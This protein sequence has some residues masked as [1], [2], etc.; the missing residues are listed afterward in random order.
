MFDSIT[1]T[2]AL[3]EHLKRTF[4]KIEYFLP[5][6]TRAGYKK[7]LDFIAATKHYREVCFMA[8]NRVGKSEAVAYC[9]AV[10]LTGK[11]PHWWT[12]KRFNKPTNIL[13]AGETARLVRDS[14]QTKLLG[15]HSNRGTGLIPKDCIISTT[16]KSGVPDAVDTVEVRHVS[17]GVSLLQFQS[18]DQGRE[19]F[20]ATARDVVIEDEEPPI[21]IHNECLIRTMTTKGIVLLAFTPLTNILKRDNN[22]KCCQA[23][24]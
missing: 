19:A 15:P 14:I 20:Q 6:H 16:A 23:F 21:A 12:G 10:W 22:V 17:G 3:A 13:V 18:Y 11:Y 5:D 8:G 1:R 4:C 7:H 2:D 9:A 24:F